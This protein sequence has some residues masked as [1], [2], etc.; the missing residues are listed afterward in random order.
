MA[1][2][3]RDPHTVTDIVDALQRYGPA[4]GAKKLLQREKEAALESIRT[5][6]YGSW[7]SVTGNDCSRVGPS[8][9]C[10]CGHKYNCHDPQTPTVKCGVCKCRHFDFVPTR[11]EEVGEWW[12]PRR[13]GFNVHKWK[14]KCRC[15]HAH[16]DH[17]P[18]T[19]RCNLC[20]C[21]LFDSAYLCLVC[22]KHQEEHST[23]FETEDERKLCGRAVGH[24]Y[25]PF[26]ELPGVQSLVYDREVNSNVAPPWRAPNAPGLGLSGC[27]R[28]L[29]TG[30]DSGNRF[31]V[32]ADS[33]GPVGSTARERYARLTDA[34]AL[35]F[36]GSLEETLG[37]GRKRH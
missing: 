19:R 36:E 32:T 5:G 15:K 35:G 37:G 13:K 29:L 7:R 8:S 6:L 21:C 12:L 24:D 25:V 22:E 34:S 1:L 27:P 31:V 26:S 23:V 20:S 4:P 11:P 3:C 18:Q 28:P 17:D 33:V 14:A 16:T 9:M 10:F 30:G 2:S